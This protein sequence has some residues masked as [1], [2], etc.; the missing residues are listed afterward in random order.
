MEMIKIHLFSFNFQANLNRGYVKLIQDTALSFI[1]TKQV[2]SNRSS[3][4]K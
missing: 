2:I 3:N 4:Y 1:L